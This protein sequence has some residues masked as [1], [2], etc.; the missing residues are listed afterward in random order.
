MMPSGDLA[1]AK[2]GERCKYVLRRREDSSQTPFGDE[3]AGP[4]A[5][6]MTYSAPIRGFSRVPEIQLANAVR[7]H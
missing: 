4:L 6:R 3:I 5:T 1:M 2:V 7:I